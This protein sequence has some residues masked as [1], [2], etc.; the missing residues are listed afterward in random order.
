MILLLICSLNALVKL[1]LKTGARE[2][3]HI[4]VLMMD[5][6]L[7]YLPSIFSRALDE[8]RLAC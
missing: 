5:V 7:H 3:D 2:T 6:K 8:V 1:M 4:A